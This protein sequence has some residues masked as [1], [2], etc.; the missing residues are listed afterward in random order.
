MILR[1]SVISS[2]SSVV[3]EFYSKLCLNHKIPT[4]VGM[5]LRFGT[6][7]SPITHHPSPSFSSVCRTQPPPNCCVKRDGDKRGL[8]VALPS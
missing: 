7:N 6:T 3:S 2:H 1:L 5:T 8:S 4:F